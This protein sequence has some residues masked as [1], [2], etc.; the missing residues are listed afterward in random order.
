LSWYED[1][2]ALRQSAVYPE[3]V[4]LA[5]VMGYG[6]DITKMVVKELMSSPPGEHTFERFVD[7]L[8]ALCPSE[9]T[10]RASHELRN[11]IRSLET[12]RHDLN[13][14]VDETRARIK[15][16]THNSTLSEDM[17]LCNVCYHRKVAIIF[18]CGH[19]KCEECANILTDTAGGKCPDCRATLRSPRRA[20]FPGGN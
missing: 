13:S 14:L 15:T 6:H 16:S 9:Q 5:L 19:L 1:G 12:Q 4:E 3:W 20:F 2:A 7:M 11:S 17:L 18:K 8:D 10:K